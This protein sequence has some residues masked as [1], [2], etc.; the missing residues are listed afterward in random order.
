LENIIAALWKGSVSLLKV[1]DLLFTP[2]QISAK[3]ALVANLM[4]VSKTISVLWTE[5]AVEFASFP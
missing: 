3:P 5:L 4:P 1:L 2:P